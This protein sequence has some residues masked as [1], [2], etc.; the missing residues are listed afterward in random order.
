MQA[1]TMLRIASRVRAS[2]DKEVEVKG[3]TAIDLY[4]TLRPLAYL[5]KVCL[6]N[7]RLG[8]LRGLGG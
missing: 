3:K 2:S 5:V 8:R 6:S 7:N 4:V 1:K